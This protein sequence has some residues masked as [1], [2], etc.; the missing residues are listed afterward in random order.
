M[1]TTV[2]DLANKA[3]QTVMTKATLFRRAWAKVGS[4]CCWAEQP[5]VRL[6]CHI[7][8]TG[9]TRRRALGL[10]HTCRDS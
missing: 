3:K 10:P 8:A 4:C 6:L 1:A 9:L 2:T 5:T 7:N